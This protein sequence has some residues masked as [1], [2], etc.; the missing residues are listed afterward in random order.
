MTIGGA[1][2]GLLVYKT[3][4]EVYATAENVD[5]LFS[6][7]TSVSIFKAGSNLYGLGLSIAN[8]TTFP[9]SAIFWSSFWGVSSWIGVKYLMTTYLS[10]VFMIDEIYLLEN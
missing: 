10:Q 2:E 1:D 7:A 3:N 8:Y 6:T 5:L 4:R 9:F